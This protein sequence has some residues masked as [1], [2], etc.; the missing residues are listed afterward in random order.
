M[1]DTKL[2]K[3]KAERTPLNQIKLLRSD[4]LALEKQIETIKKKYEQYFGT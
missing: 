1:Q 3:E 2:V 4:P